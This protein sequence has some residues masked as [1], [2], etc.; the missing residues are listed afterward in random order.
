[1]WDMSSNPFP[2]RHRLAVLDPWLVD[3]LRDGMIHYRD[4]LEIHRNLAQI[5]GDD[6]YQ[7]T[8]KLCYADAAIEQLDRE[9]G[10]HA[11]TYS[12]DPQ[13]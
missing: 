6:T 1:M 12:Q 13:H 5:T 10:N 11:C 8:R 9:K 4:T 3:T 7:L 2:Y